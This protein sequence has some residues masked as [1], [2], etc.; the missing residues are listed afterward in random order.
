MHVFKSVQYN[1]QFTSL[2]FHIIS[3]G[4][5]C[6]PGGFPYLTDEKFTSRS[7]SVKFLRIWSF[8]WSVEQFPPGYWD[9]MYGFNL[10]LSLLFLYLYLSPLLCIFYIMKLKKLIRIKFSSILSIFYSATFLEKHLI[11]LFPHQVPYKNVGQLGLNQSKLLY[12]IH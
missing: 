2:D 3:W 7:H 10:F 9:R 11:Q 12:E 5:C 1:C 8:T 6:Q 4:F